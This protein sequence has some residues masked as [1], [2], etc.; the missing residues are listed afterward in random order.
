MIRSVE[1]QGFRGIRRGRLD[2]LTPLVV[3][4]GPNGS[5]KSTVLDAILIGASPVPAEATGQ[6]VARREGLDQGTR[7]LFFGGGH[8]G[9]AKITVVT[10]AEAQRI[11]DLALDKGVNFPKARVQGSV[12]I[13]LQG[14]QPSDSGFTIDFESGNKYTFSGRGSPMPLPDVPEVRLVDPRCHALRTPLHQLR[15][16]IREHGRLQQAKEILTTLLPDVE[17]I[18]IEVEGDRPLLYLAY[19]DRGVPVALA[20][21]G[22]RLLVELA[23][24]LVA[25]LGGVVL[26][27]EPE[28]HMHP[29]A[30]HQFARVAMAT[31]R[32]GVQIVLTT[33]SLELIDSLLGEISDAELPLLSLYSMRLEDGRLVSSRLAGPDV[34]TSRLQ[35]EY[36]LR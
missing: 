13:R 31:V 23:F 28:A 8:T 9:S 7:W 14:G 24:E 33:H 22:V 4:V 29:G 16:A 3:L 34:A 1:I 30:I 35:I 21:D 12:S 26:L 27:E 17:D 15:T 11:C 5:G 19:P 2:N 25:R 10:S 6:A 18:S 32:R 20:G 36:D